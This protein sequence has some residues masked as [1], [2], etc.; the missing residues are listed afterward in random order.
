MV[1]DYNKMSNFSPAN[2]RNEYFKSKLLVYSMWTALRMNNY[3]PLTKE[4]K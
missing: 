4:G 1:L 2:F 3:L